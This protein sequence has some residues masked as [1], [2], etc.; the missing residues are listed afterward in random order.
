MHAQ[1][2]PAIEWRVVLQPVRV[3][4]GPR[5]VDAAY[6]VLLK[7]RAHACREEDDADR[8]LCARVD[9]APRTRADH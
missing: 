6:Q 2:G 9:G 1:A 4:D 8:D 5:R 7:P 3:R